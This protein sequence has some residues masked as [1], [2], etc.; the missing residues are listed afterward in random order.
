MHWVTLSEEIITEAFHNEEAEVIQQGRDSAPTDPVPGI[1]AGLAARIRAAVLACGR[2]RLQGG[3]LSIPQA[4]RGEATA[5][6]R[7]KLLVRFA[8][9][10]SEDRRLEAQDAEKRLDAIA[11]GELP[12]A[13][14]VVHHL[15]TY[16]GRKQ[17]WQSPR[18]GG[19]M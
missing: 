11:R 7:F 12:L 5:I 13:E 4:L 1:L 8:L 6:L 2:V 16:K 17:R 19:V 14:D 15:P 18:R 9:N 3:E 10:V